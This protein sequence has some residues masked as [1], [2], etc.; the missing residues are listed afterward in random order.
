MNK[1]IENLTDEEIQE[2]EIPVLEKYLEETTNKVASDNES[3][4]RKKFTKVDYL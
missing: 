4:N 2:I 1:K 3:R